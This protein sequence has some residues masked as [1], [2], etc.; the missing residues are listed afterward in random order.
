MMMERFYRRKFDSCVYFKK[1]INENI[2]YFLL[3]I[4]NML[5]ICKDMVD[6]NELKEALKAEFEMKDLGAAK[7][8]LGLIFLEIER[9]VFYL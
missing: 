5:I 6:I 1:T 3:F 8:I 4:D 9:K 7:R 2:I